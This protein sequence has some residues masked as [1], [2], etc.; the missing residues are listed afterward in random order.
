MAKILDDKQR[1]EAEREIEQ[2]ERETRKSVEKT[3]SK[4]LN[5]SWFNNYS[6]IDKYNRVLWIF[7]EIPVD[8]V[9]SDFIGKNYQEVVRKLKRSGFKYIMEEPVKDLSIN[10]I[11]KDNFGIRCK[12]RLE[13]FF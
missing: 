13:R 2:K 9:D 10:D 6:Y 7:Y 5:N 12:N 8:Y 11:K 3:T 1:K 4:G